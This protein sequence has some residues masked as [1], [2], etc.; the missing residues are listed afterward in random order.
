MLL[1]NYRSTSK[2]IDV[3]SDP[4]L[5]AWHHW[6]REWR[7]DGSLAV[8]EHRFRR[9]LLLA[10]TRNWS[11]TSG[12]IAGVGSKWLLTEKGWLGPGMPSRLQKPGCPGRA[13]MLS[14]GDRM[15]ALFSA[16]QAWVAMREGASSAL[17][18]WPREAW[19][20]L[21]ARWR[22]RRPHEG[23]SQIAEIA[24]SLAPRKH[25]SRP[26]RRRRR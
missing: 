21:D 11:P 2:C 22:K 6:L 5:L 25:M 3:R 20:W 23:G 13:G 12:L 7:D 15:S 8:V 10:A 17:P 4:E 14:P 18:K 26:R 19:H 24:A 1:L 9:D 16:W